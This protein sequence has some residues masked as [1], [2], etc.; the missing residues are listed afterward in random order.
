MAT[1]DWLDGETIVRR[2]DGREFT[3]HVRSGK[4]KLIADDGMEPTSFIPLT[5]FKNEIDSGKYRKTTM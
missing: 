5:E 1:L 4:V 2:E 3:V